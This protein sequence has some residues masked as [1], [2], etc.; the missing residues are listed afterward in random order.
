[1]L[2]NV[3]RDIARADRVWYGS[4]FGSWCVLSSAAMVMGLFAK[5]G[6]SRLIILVSYFAVFVVALHSFLVAMK[7]K[8]QTQQFPSRLTFLT[9]LSGVPWIVLHFL[10]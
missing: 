6:T 5:T 4:V 7:A 9:L 8:P 2:S 10:K 1:M 3:K